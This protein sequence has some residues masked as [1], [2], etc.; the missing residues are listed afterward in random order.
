MQKLIVLLSGILFMSSVLMAQTTS[1]NTDFSSGHP[2]GNVY[3]WASGE[4]SASVEG[5]EMKVIYDKSEDKMWNR[6]VFWVKPFDITLSP[7]CRFS[8]K[9]DKDFQ[10]TLE[11]KD[12]TGA[13]ISRIFGVTTG[14]QE[15]E[16]D[17]SSDMGQLSSNILSEL[18]WDVGFNNDSG[19]FWLDDFK[20]GTAAKPA[21]GDRERVTRFVDDF[22]EGIV[23]AYWKEDESY[24]F[25][26]VN[27]TLVID[28]NK[29]Y[30]ENAHNF[31]VEF[32]PL[33][34]MTD[35]AYMSLDVKVSKSV[36]IY[37]TLYD[38]QDR[39][40]RSLHRV[41]DA[42]QM[43]PLFL[44]LG[45]S[46]EVDYTT[47]SRMEIN[48]GMTAYDYTGVVT[49]DNLRL[50][51]VVTPRANILPIPDHHYFMNTKGATLFLT[52]IEHA[53]NVEFT[54]AES[55]VENVVSGTVKSGLATIT[56]DCIDG[57]F[58]SDT[59]TVISRGVEGYQDGFVKTLLTVE[60][61]NPPVINPLADLELDITDSIVQVNYDGIRDNNIS[62]DQQLTVEVLSLDESVVKIADLSYNSP[63]HHGSLQ[64]KLLQSGTAGVVVTVT[65]DIAEA[66]STRDTFNIS[67]F[68]GFNHKPTVDHPGIVKFFT[69]QS[70]DTLYLTG[71]TDGDQGVEGLTFDVATNDPSVIV[72]V[73]ATGLSGDSLMIVL[74]SQAVGSTTV[75]VTVKDDGGTTENNGDQEIRIGFTVNVVD[76]PVTGYVADF[77]DVEG[78]VARG[79]WAAGGVYA[80][81]TVDSS[82][83]GFY[84]MRVDVTGKT[85]WDGSNLNF[86]PEGFE[87]DLSEHP[88]FSMEIYPLDDNTLHWLWFYD[89]T[90]TRNDL[91]NRTVDKLVWAESGKWNDV[92]YKYS[93]ELDWRNKEQ[94]YDIDNSRIVKILFDM[95]NA[96]FTW[97]P[98]PDYT[99]S[100]LIRNLRIGSEV[101]QPAPSAVMPTIDKMTIDPV[102][103]NTEGNQVMLTGITDGT[104][105]TEGVTVSVMSSAENI[106]EIISVK[107]VS[108]EG[109]SGFTFHAKE[110]GT[111]QV[112]ITIS[113]GNSEEDLV[114]REW[115]Y[116]ISAQ[117]NNAV[118]VGIDA[119]QKHQ[120]IRGFG[121]Y[122]DSKNGEIYTKVMNASAVRLGLISNQIEWENDN[123]DPHVLNME[124]FDDNAFDWTY[125]RQLKEDGVESFILTSWSPPAW[126]K[127][128]LSLSHWQAD[129]SPSSD[130][131]MNRLSYHYY[132]EFAEEMVAVIRMFKE[133]AGIDLTGIGLQNEPA[134]HE[135][136]PSAILD[137]THFNDLIKIVGQR[138]EQEGINTLLYMPEQ[139]FTQGY[140]SMADYIDMLQSDAEANR[141]SE[142]IASHNYAENG[143]D[144]ATPDLSEWTR[145][146]NNS[147]EGDH[148]KE[149]W[150]TESTREYRSFSDAIYIAAGIQGALL[151]GNVSLWTQFSFA[152]QFLTSGKPNSMLYVM[153]NF[154]RYIRP[155]AERLE[156]SSSESPLMASAFKHPESDAVSLVIVNLSDQNRSVDISAANLPYLY[157]SYRTSSH[158]DCKFVGETDITRLVVIPSR[159]VTTLYALENSMLTMERIDNMVIEKNSGEQEVV[160]TGIGNGNEGVSGLTIHAETDDQE[161]ITGLTSASISGD[162][163]SRLTFIPGA[164]RTGMARVIVTLSDGETERKESFYVNVPE[165]QGTGVLN[166]HAG[167]GFRVYPN[168]AKHTLMVKSKDPIQR[169]EV[170]TVTGNLLAA[171]SGVNMNEITMYVSFLKPG[172][173]FIR[174][175]NGA[176]DVGYSSFVKQ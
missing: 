86:L 143:I 109:V 41:L 104:G 126:M 121:S 33:I 105:S 159:S 141:L 45:G 117:Y 144:V 30:N 29:G 120:T 146:W 34:D 157:D 27:N 21:V 42:G 149:L 9:G 134:F 48:V 3:D 36:L 20:M 164:D 5:E 87:L 137:P 60:G 145:M 130:E 6:L 70:L 94:G 123:N 170:I 136:Y 79:V 71:V 156:S 61:N 16:L 174:L 142:V 114:V 26:N 69:G 92:S 131:V 97:P 89:Y 84:A 65:E 23:P 167:P 76:Q 19:T 64:L 80:L 99:G 4:I 46:G 25:S 98:P 112:T 101:Q 38:Y 107:P 2:F 58:G 148:P 135:P 8:I 14:Y 35:S 122:M 49:L 150:M 72:P 113:G 77:S 62:L 63:M 154:S 162:G 56:F 68:E 133:R 51:G 52:D 24:S 39:P 119:A 171:Q 91:N 75:E 83:N 12:E 166:D 153:R 31:F 95:H 85:Y 128:N 155:G 169:V 66:G 160:I 37:F 22:N 115:V 88:Y 15:I 78:D 106:A 103:E 73:S 132:E 59:I 172:L 32:P 18:Q 175:T 40:I 53:E 28:I 110:P 81:S 125:L 158:E 118:V 17:L 93:G 10:M 152:D 102:L 13:G 163:M 176:G 44:D 54:G 116:I 173:Y 165:S 100:F 57:V 43:T 147:Q 1:Y 108:D 82:A 111:V 50:G 139:V 67:I 127:D 7:Y 161:L 151:G 124:A 140:P 129:H 138:F 47:I 168:P 11:F 74:E 90:N 55:L 96:E